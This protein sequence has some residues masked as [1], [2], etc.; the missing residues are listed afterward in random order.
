MLKLLNDTK[1]ESEVVSNSG[2]QHALIEITQN[3]LKHGV[4]VGGMIPGYLCLEW[5]DKALLASTA[6]VI[7]EEDLFKIKTKL[8]VLNKAS[9]TELDKISEKALLDFSV[10]GGLGL[11][12]VAQLSRPNL[13]NYYVTDLKKFGKTLIFTTQFD[14]A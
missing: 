10:E 2:F 1:K 12:T 4:K 8:E 3:V 9:E 13:L 6:S 5:K 7:S 14:K 11:I